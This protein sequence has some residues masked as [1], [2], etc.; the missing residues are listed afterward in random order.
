[1][2]NNF[3]EL[4]KLKKIKK[5]KKTQLRKLEA[6]ALKEQDILLPDHYCDPI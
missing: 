4:E 2:E 3:L 5:E 1:M 6:V